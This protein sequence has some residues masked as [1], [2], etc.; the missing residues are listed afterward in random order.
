M[1]SEV[2]TMNLTP[3]QLQAVSNG[4]AFRFTEAGSEYVVVRAD[5]YE[6]ARE[7]LEEEQDRAVERARL[8]AAKK[9]AAA[10][11]QDNPY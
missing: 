7:L 9:A 11:M 4:Q 1:T 10:F 2:T 8:T 6:R 3:D 5:I